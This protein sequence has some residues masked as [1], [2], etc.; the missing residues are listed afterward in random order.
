MF[1]PQMVTLGAVVGMGVWLAIMFRWGDRFENTPAI[2]KI[3]IMAAFA[4]GGGAIF[5]IIAERASRRDRHWKHED[6]K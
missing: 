2:V 1:V 3:A 4:A 6:K 5:G